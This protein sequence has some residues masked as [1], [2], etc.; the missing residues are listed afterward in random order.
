MSENK[1]LQWSDQP[2]AP[3]VTSSYFFEKEEQSLGC[4]LHRMWVKN[5][6]QRNDSNFMI[7]NVTNEV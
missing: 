2:D 3:C 7:S 1:N 4:M 5:Q 6:L